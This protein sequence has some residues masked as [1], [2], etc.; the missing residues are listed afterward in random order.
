MRIALRRMNRVTFISGHGSAC[1]TVQLPMRFPPPPQ[2]D[3]GKKKT[4]SNFCRPNA[5]PVTPRLPQVFLPKNP[6][7]L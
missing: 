2:E 6:L 3:T 1:G 4:A 5:D 7:A